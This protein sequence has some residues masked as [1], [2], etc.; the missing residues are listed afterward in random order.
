LNLVIVALEATAVPSGPTP[1]T[2]N[3]PIWMLTRSGR[4]SNPVG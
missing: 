3:G 2:E 1:T 4:L